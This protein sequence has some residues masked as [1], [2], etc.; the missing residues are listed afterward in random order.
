VRINCLSL[1]ENL[2]ILNV[3]AGTQ[4]PLF[5][6]VEEVAGL[7]KRIDRVLVES[8]TVQF[9]LDNEAKAAEITEALEDVDD[10][11]DWTVRALWDGMNS[12]INRLRARRPVPTLDISRLLAL[13]DKVLP[14]GTSAVQRA[15]PEEASAARRAM[16]GLDEQDRHLLGTIPS[17][18][19]GSQL[20][21][22]QE[23][24]VFGLELEEL[25]K[26]RSVLLGGS[27][28][29]KKEYEA[30]LAGW[31]VI[32]LVLRALEDAAAPIETLTALRQPALDQIRNAERRAD[33]RAR[34]PKPAPKPAESPSTPSTPSEDSASTDVTGEATGSASSESPEESR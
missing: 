10:R 20:D 4:R 27:S 29:K 7:V 32:D 6:S 16:D 18:P 14:N 19:E 24:A 28:G 26:R 21:V 15:Y 2:V 34:A 23:R 13:R 12:A 9:S 31:Q 17:F 3:W 8:R 5:V 11:H 33:Q 25:G 22:G 30:R 1:N